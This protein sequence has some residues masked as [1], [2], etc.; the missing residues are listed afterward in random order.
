MILGIDLGTTFSAGAYIDDKGEPQIAS[1][2]DGGKLT[3]SVVFLILITTM[4]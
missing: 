4:R 2:N 3:P 1:N